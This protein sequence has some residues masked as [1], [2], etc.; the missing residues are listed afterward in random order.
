MSN[1]PAVTNRNLAIQITRDLYYELKQEASTRRMTLSEFCRFI[2]N[3]EITR[4]GT[5]LTDDVKE[6]IK[7]EI[8]NAERKR[9]S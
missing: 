1:M 5:V 3:E 4:L 2:L 6:I 8:E 7:K 9:H